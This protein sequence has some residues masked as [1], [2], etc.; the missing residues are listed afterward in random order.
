MPLEPAPAPAVP[1][2]VAPAGMAGPPPTAAGAAVPAVIVFAPI[3]EST[4][5]FEESQAISQ[6]DKELSTRYDAAP[7][8]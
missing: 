4:A 8:R 5:A 7:T 1:L 3:P 2:P 6:S